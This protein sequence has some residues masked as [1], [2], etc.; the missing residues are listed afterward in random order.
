MKEYLAFIKEE[1][2]DINGNYLYK[3]DFSTDK[4]TVWGEYWNVVPSSI[5]PTLDIDVKCVS[6]AFRAVFPIHLLTAD[7]S[8]CFSMQDCIDGIISLAY[9]NIDE[10]YLSYDEKPLFFN[11]GEDYEEVITK[12]NSLNIQITNEQEIDNENNDVEL[13][14]ILEK[15]NDNDTD[16]EDYIFD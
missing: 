4:D 7:K 11:F 2:K 6:K 10:E 9:S 16:D 5:I 12:L 8:N 13:S 14:R 15:K 1:G 3:F